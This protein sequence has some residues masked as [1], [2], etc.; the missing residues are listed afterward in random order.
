[1]ARADNLPSDASVAAR[2]K[3]LQEVEQAPYDHDFYQLL[4]R[5]EYLQIGKPRFGQAQRPHEESVRLAQEPSLS[6]APA[7]ISAMD[8]NADGIPRISVRF[9]GL[10]GPH[11]PLPTHLTE[12]AR[13]RMR[14]HSDPTL[15]RF[16]DLF[17]HRLLLLFYRAW[18]QAQPAASHDQPEHDRFLTYLGALFGQAGDGWRGRDGITDS[19]KRQFTGHLA[20]SA[21]CADSLTSLLAAYFKVTVTVHSFAPQWLPMPAADRTRLGTGS[22]C[23]LGASA[24]LGARVHDC[25]HQIALEL[26]PMS[27]ARYETFLPGGKSL[28]RLV[29]WMRNY[30]ADELNWRATLTLRSDEVCSVRLAQSGRLGLTSWLGHSP[31]TQDR[32]DLHLTAASHAVSAPSLV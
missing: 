14:S 25:Q 20:R 10:F 9:L 1:M 30:L 23:Q 16:A 3:L 6:F 27:L 15:A 11:G 17:H 24:V 2:A 12:L 21:K 13:E 8:Y 28:Q 31:P 22:S 18:R 4:R 29:D 7:N 19:S 26:G 5:L 32:G